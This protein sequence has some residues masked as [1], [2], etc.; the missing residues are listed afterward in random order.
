MISG[1][2]TAA[3][4]MI[5]EQRR[6]EI[7]S[8]NLNNMDT[9][10]Y[11]QDNTKLRAFP[12]MLMQRIGGD[13]PVAN[14]GDLPTG[15]YAEETVPDFSQGTLTDT[16]KK[17]DVALV[18]NQLPVNPTTGAQ[19]GALLFS[20]QTPAGA[21][22][23]TRDGHFT[24]NAA[25]QLTDDAGDKVLDTNGNPIRVNSE[26]IQVASDGTITNSASGAQLGQIGVSYAANTNQLVK[27]GGGLYRLQN[28]TLPSATGQANVAY[29]LKQGSLEGSNVSPDE[30]MTDMMGAYRSFEANQKVLLILDNT[31]D[32]AVNQV[33]RIN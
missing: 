30:T 26:D 8:N 1:L 20:V 4:G 15:V 18:T 2:Y 24:L 17:T 22:R 12:E 21:V 11:K 16:G 9:P 13:T 29:Q 14:I 3:S 27:E 6:Q 33:G 25:G 5:A 23:Y 32:K 7:L 28:G 19:E 31:L 10:G